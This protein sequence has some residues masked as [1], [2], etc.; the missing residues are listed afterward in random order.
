MKGYPL[1]SCKLVESF[2]HIVKERMGMAHHR[3]FYDV[4]V[5]IISYI[6]S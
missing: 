6:K 1:T 5:D 4:N 2:V 3:H